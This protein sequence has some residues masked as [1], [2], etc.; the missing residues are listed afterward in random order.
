[1]KFLR[2][3]LSLM[4]ALRY[5]N[6]LRNAFS[7]MTLICLIGVSLGVMVLIVVLS[8]ME[9]LQRDMADKVLTFTP[10]YVVEASDDVGQSRRLDDMEMDWE[11]AIKKIQQLPGVISAYPKLENDAFIQSATA[12]SSYRFLSVQPQ[13]ES[14]LSYLRP[15]IIRGTIDFGLGLDQQCVVSNKLAESL[16]VD[17]GDTVTLNPLGGLNEFENIYKLIVQPLRTHEN[18]TFMQDISTLF[19]KIEAGEKGYAPAR[20]KIASIKKDIESF[21]P[22]NLRDAE[23]LALTT[24]H[25]LIF[26]TE[27]LGGYFSE[28]DKNLWQKTAHQLAQLDRHRVNGE[29]IDSVNELALPVDLTII[30]VY[31][32]PSNLPGPGLFLPLP[33]A[34]EALSYNVDGKNQ[35]QAISI[36][37][38]DAHDNTYLPELVFSSLQDTFISDTARSYNWSIIPWTKSLEQWFRLIANERTMMSFVLSIIS[39]IAAFCIMAV[40]FTMSMQR[41][42]EIAVMQALGA[43][44]WKIMR[45][46]L[47]Q[48]L[49]I[50]FFGALLGILLALLV[51][52]Y[53]LD[54]QWALASIGLDPFPMEAHGISLPVY[55]N[56]ATFIQQGVTAFLMVLI[57]SIIPAF[58]ISRQ[59]P[60][61]ALRSN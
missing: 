43:T 60:S 35:V 37:M 54:I 51:L 3:H 58:F 22:Q 23:Q 8:V 42:R 29:A 24:L 48:G 40:M 50:G 28:S 61:K 31:Q 56:P 38:D 55:Y 18:Q 11:R 59:D 47:W 36:R 4:L 52:Y 12:S 45:I 13:N 41:K 27:S 33:I 14:Q 7:I 25:Q 53:R 46:F 10:H 19:D 15:L 17:V 5:L 57:A 2:R 32:A 26:A 9:G 44:P 1:M 34:Q 21:N 6:P 39:L 49:I 16:K 20:E 30:G